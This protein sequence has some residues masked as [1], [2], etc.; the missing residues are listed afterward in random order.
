MTARYALFVALALSVLVVPAGADEKLAIDFEATTLDGGTFDASR[1][2]GMVVLLDFWAVWCPP[3]ISAMP[4]LSRLDHE[5]GDRGFH[6]VGIAVHSGGPEDVAQFLED[7]EVSYTIVVGD[8]DLTERFGG[9]GFPTYF[10]IGADGSVFKMYVGEMKNM[11]DKL[12]R[13]IETLL[14]RAGSKP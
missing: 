14:S 4:T 5:L 3:C 7:K 2:E 9:I 10:L 6:V 1:L 13:D 11:Q 8:E 12:E